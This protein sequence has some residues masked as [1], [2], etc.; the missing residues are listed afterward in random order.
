MST[1]SPLSQAVVALSDTLSAPVYTPG[2]PASTVSSA[3]LIKLIAAAS[4]VVALSDAAEPTVAPA[5]FMTRAQIMQIALEAL[6]ADAEV[7]AVVR[8]PSCSPLPDQTIVTRIKRVCD[9]P[10]D[11]LPILFTRATQN[12]FSWQC[13][14][15]EAEDEGILT[16]EIV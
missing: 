3:W 1:Q 9:D 6:N 10:D 13:I 16:L 2:A 14:F 11:D 5:A 7:R 15:S 8:F 12:D 4:R